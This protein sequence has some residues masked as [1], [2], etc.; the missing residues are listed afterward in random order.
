MIAPLLHLPALRP[1][2]LL[3]L[4]AV[5]GAGALVPQPTA[6]LPWSPRFR[7][8][9]IRC[10]GRHCEVDRVRVRALLETRAGLASAAR[11]V[12]SVGCGQMIGIRLYAIRPASLLARLGLRNG[13]KLVR[14]N[15]ISLSSPETALRL[16]AMLKTAPFVRLELER[17]GE[18]TT[19]TYAIR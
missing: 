12:P 16:Y 11:F 3:S 13:D 18:R 7:D 15:G 4:L 6:L 1:A 9:A 8:E 10:S 14:V 17:H 19:L 5:C 2:V